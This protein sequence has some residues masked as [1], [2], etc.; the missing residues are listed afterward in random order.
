MMCI[1]GNLQQILDQ[2]P[3]WPGGASK[4]D[5][6]SGGNMNRLSDDASPWVGLPDYARN[7]CF[8]NWEEVFLGLLSILH[9]MG[10]P[11]KAFESTD[12][13]SLAYFLAAIVLKADVDMCVQGLTQV[14][15]REET[16]EYITHSRIGYLQSYWN[17]SWI[18][19]LQHMLL[20]LRQF[21][22]EKIDKLTK[23][24]LFRLIHI[25]K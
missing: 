2:N 17:E 24:N 23:K 4:Y 25:H 22:P 20:R 19:I 1:L 16:G 15:W 3:S 13:F 5:N 18:Y 10:G 8:L 7:E 12:I 11:G 21:I 6:S 14:K 9:L